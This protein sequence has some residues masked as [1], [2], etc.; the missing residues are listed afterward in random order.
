MSGGEGRQSEAAHLPGARPQTEGRD[1][2]RLPAA[3]RRDV[4]VLGEALGQVLREDGTPGLFEDVERIRRGAIALRA[5]PTEQASRSVLATVSGLTRE[6][7]EEVARAF[8]VYFHLVNLADER[9][10]VRTLRERGQGEEPMGGSLEAAVAQI[11]AA[12]GTEALDAL[13]ARL[14]VAPVITAHPTEAR[15]RSVVEALQRLAAQLAQLDDPAA[16]RVERAEA[17]RHLLEEV[18]ILWRTAQLRSHR[19]DPLD[20]VRALMAVFD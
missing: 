20:E 7:A 5:H 19:P 10:R 3:L 1:G 15:R 12:E 9:H 18:A 2:S 13:L 17:R 4:R 16:S 11:R 14:A 8:T 6:R